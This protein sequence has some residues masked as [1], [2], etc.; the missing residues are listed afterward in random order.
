MLPTNPPRE[1]LN[2]KNVLNPTFY[3]RKL[4]EKRVKKQAASSKDPS[5]RATLSPD[6]HLP[7]GSFLGENPSFLHKDGYE[8]FRRRAEKYP[9]PSSSSRLPCM[10]C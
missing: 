7:P 1:P 5:Q 3:S 6:A 4:A 9:P 10:V 2:I 8:F